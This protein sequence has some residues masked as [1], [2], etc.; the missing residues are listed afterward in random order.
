MQRNILVCKGKAGIRVKTGGKSVVG[1]AH[2]LSPECPA[3]AHQH[4]YPH[5]QNWGAGML[6]VFF[7]F[8]QETCS[9]Q[10]NH[11]PSVLG[12]YLKHLPAAMQTSSFL[13]V[14]AVWSAQWPSVLFSRKELGSFKVRR[15]LVKMVCTLCHGR[16]MFS[17]FTTLMQS[18]WF[19]LQCLTVP[20]GDG[21]EMIEVL[22]LSFE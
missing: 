22:V 6:N 13:C 3:M 15:A 16:V 10:L 1:Q 19:S 11:Q 5:F 8:V 14:C 21:E 2:L 9:H 12:W 7:K 18:D 20:C 4:C 17:V